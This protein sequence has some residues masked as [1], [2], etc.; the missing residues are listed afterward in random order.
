MGRHFDLLFDS[1]QESDYAD[2]VTFNEDEVGPWLDKTKS[3][4]AH[5]E[6]LIN[7]LIEN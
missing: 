3:F 4:V 5:V 6:Q 2:F 7:N 1:R